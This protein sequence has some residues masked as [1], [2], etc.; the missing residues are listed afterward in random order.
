MGGWV[1]ICG[2]VV[3]S[4]VR[5]NSRELGWA[6][7]RDLFTRQSAKDYILQESWVRFAMLANLKELATC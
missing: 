6:F 5:R 3:N 7:V 2:E 4:I 1:G